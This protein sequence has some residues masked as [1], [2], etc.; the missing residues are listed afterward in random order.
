MFTVYAVVCVTDRIHV[1]VVCECYRMCVLQDVCVCV[2]YV[3]C[4]CTVCVCVCGFF[5]FFFEEG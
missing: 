1:D 5:F 2:V 4:V 3:W